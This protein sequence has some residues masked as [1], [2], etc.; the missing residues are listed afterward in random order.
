VTLELLPHHLNK[1]VSLESA[2]E[3]F[4]SLQKFLLQ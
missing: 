3:E 4:Q 1:E 2:L